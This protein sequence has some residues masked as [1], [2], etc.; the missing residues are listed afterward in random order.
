MRKT[1]IIATLGPACRDEETLYSM[2]QNG[3][4]V[5][6]LNLSHGDFPLHKKGIDAVRRAAAR[7]G[8]PVAIMMDTR[9]PEI[10]IGDMENGGV[11]L[12]AGETFVFST[13]PRVGNA[14]GVYIDDPD[15]PAEIKAGARLLLDDG[16]MAFTVL[17][18]KDTEIVCRTDTDGILPS[19]KSVSV[20]H[21]PLSL[22]FL[23]EKDRADLILGIKE[24]IDYVAAS[25]V[26]SADDI[27]TLRRFLAENGAPDVGIIAKIENSEGIDNF[28]AILAATDAVMVARGDMGVEIPFTRLPGIQ[29]TFI[30]KCYE[31]G[32]T[33]IT[34]TQMLESMI[35][36]STPTRAEITDVANA[37]FDGTSAVMLSGETAMGAHPALVVRTMADIAE[38]AEADMAMAQNRKIVY[39]ER[40]SDVTN[41]VCDAATRAARDIHAAALVALTKTGEAARLLAKYRPSE[42]I[43]AVTP[44]ETTYRRLALVWGVVPMLSSYRGDTESLFAHAMETVKKSGYLSV[45]DRVVMTAGLP[46]AAAG[47]TNLLRIQTVE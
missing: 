39:D 27:L 33:V 16:K 29:K 13:R 30:R 28:D 35:H 20:P 40:P 3:M 44:E 7:L 32:K 31:A 21:T 46:L 6:R 22:P 15:L 41:A 8:I 34:A 12:H 26:R 24:G 37:V 18:V 19:H 11:A 5:A 1:K 10:R 38:A 45:G 9:G 43:L 23:S 17:N 42:T 25:F 36:D 14:D 4:N 2:M 47:N